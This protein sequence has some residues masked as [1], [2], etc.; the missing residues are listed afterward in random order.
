LIVNTSP[1]LTDLIQAVCKTEPEI[2]IVGAVASPAQ[3]NQRLGQFDV[4]VV[5]AAAPDNHALTLLRTWSRLD[6]PPPVVV[7]GLPESEALVLRYLEA[8]AAGC[9]RNQDSAQG[10]V[11]AI[12]AA[13]KRQVALSQDLL[14]AVMRRVVALADEC[15]AGERLS[16]RDFEEDLTRREL[17]VLGL[18]ARGY[19]NR[20]IAAELTIELGTA[21]NHVHNIL[22]KLKVKNRKD[23]AVYLSLGLI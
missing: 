5:S 22:D 13:S 12:R 10:L 19:G 18:I 20:E 15:R 7:I 3:A 17:Q 14:G 1:F 11:H 23:A 8:G 4:A 2:K 6:Q 9:I 21:K 16:T